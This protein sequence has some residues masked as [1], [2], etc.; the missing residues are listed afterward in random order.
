M[1]K[2]GKTYENRLLAALAHGSVVAQGIGILVGVLVYITQRD[3]SRFAAFQALQAAVFQLISLVVTVVLWL[4][5]GACYGLSMVPLIVQMDANPEAAPPAIFWVSMLGMMI[6]L[7][8]MV[9]VGLYGLWG[10][11]RTWQGKDFR[12]FLVGSWLEKSGLWNRES[13]VAPV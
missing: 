2:E 9:L 7:F 11:W 4:F 13:S 1:D 6:P 10:A 5:W 8:Y 12:Y 3:K